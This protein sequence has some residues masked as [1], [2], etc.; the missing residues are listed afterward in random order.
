M[1]VYFSGRG[2]KSEENTVNKNT[3][4][5]KKIENSGWERKYLNS[6]NNIAFLRL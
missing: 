1:H 6:E 3:K 4:R 5:M 2:I